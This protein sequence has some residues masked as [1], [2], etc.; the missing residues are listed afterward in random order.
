MS[1][2]TYRAL[3]ER[4]VTV[5][6]TISADSHRAARDLLRSRGLSVEQVTQQSEARSKSWFPF[7]RRNRYT[8]RRIEMVRELRQLR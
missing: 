4:A 7:R 3:D 1:V 2:F 5:E 6:G 8:A